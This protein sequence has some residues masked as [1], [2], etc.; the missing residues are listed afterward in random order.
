MIKIYAVEGLDE[1]VT[2]FPSMILDNYVDDFVV[3]AQGSAHEVL[4]T[5]V[6][7]SDMLDDIMRQEFEGVFSV[8]KAAVVASH[9]GLAHSLRQKLGQLGG[10]PVKSAKSLGVDFTAGRKYWNCRGKESSRKARLLKVG[11]R[12]GRMRRIKKA[13]GRAARKVAFAGSLP[14][15]A[16]GAEVTGLSDGQLLALQRI[17]ASGL[18]PSSHGRSLTATLTVNED[19]SFVAAGAP[20]VRWAREVWN[21]A[22]GADPRAYSLPELRRLWEAADAWSTS[23][24]T[25]CRGP[26]GAMALALKRWGWKAPSPFVLEDDLGRQH[27]LTT[28]SPKL[29]QR[30]LGS[31]AKRAMERKIADSSGDMALKGKRVFMDHII[32]LTKQRAKGISE[33]EQGVLLSVV[34]QAVWPQSRLRQ[35]GYQVDSRCQL[36]LEEEDTIFHRVWKCSCSKEIREKLASPILIDKAIL[37]GEDSS[38]FTR[39]LIPHPGDWWPQAE[40]EALIRREIFEVEDS[41]GLGGDIF[42]DGSC[43]AH[44]AREC[45]RAGWGL[46]KVGPDGQLLRRYSGP[47]PA[48]YAQTPQTAEFMA[49]IMLCRELTADAEAFGDCKVVVDSHH[50]GTEERL[51]WKRANAGMARAAMAERGGK[52]LKELHKVKAHVK[53]EEVA[54]DCFLL[55]CAK[56]NN[57][58]DGAAK[59]GV[60]MHP[61][62]Y[63]ERASSF[64]DLAA[65]AKTICRVI[66]ATCKLWPKAKVQGRCEAAR[67]AR[68]A[69][70]RPLPS[71]PHA[72]AAAQGGYWRCEMCLSATWSLSAL[73]SRRK[74]ECA[75]ASEALRKCLSQ[76]LGHRLISLQFDQ[77]PLVFCLAC[78]SWCVAHPVALLKP[79]PGLE[80]ASRAGRQALARVRRGEHPSG[81]GGRLGEGSRP[82]GGLVREAA[83]A[84]AAE[85]RGRQGAVPRL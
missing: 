1:L 37:A 42:I 69:R 66:A 22:A 52:F 5:V 39:G 38:L 58:A 73:E 79:C 75:G 46:V 28:T 62:P 40:S 27:V 26:M 10:K 2:R 14:A 65:E 25:S 51:H 64:K 47:V 29:M 71:R 53:E 6:E 85:L 11:A 15:A 30:E 70:R 21:S 17:V 13:G 4:E 23:K 61:Q 72:W 20:I 74:E 19:R 77:F 36:C 50:L 49:Y 9:P 35:A 82:L 12:R 16:Y 32:A 8:D 63:I 76:Q 34:C 54:E 45:S 44:P 59:A 55:W 48:K 41:F 24:W 68:A 43:D 83:A 67:L 84:A 57:A 3:G 56:G 78:G 33:H 80:G 18:S 81:R 31:S 7:A 60:L